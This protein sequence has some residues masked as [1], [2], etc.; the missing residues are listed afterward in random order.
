MSNVETLVPKPVGRSIGAIL[1]EAGRLKL[2]D[3]E[4]IMR[5]QREQ[6]LRFGDAALQLGLVSEAD[7][8]FA[9]SHQYGYP[10]LVRGETKVSEALVAAYT[11][12][13]PQVE[14]LRALRSQLMLRWFDVDNAHKALAVTSPGRKEGC[15]FVAAS[16]AVV[17]SQLGERTLL[18][19]GDLRNPSQHELFGVSNRVGLSTALSGRPWHDA[20]QRIP[21]LLSLSVLPAGALPPNALELLSRPV[22][23]LMLNELAQRFDV[24]L[25]DT[26]AASDCS[27]A[28]TIA[29]RAGAALIVARRN[30]TR[31]APLRALAE[32]AKEMG[33]VVVGTVFNDF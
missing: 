31:M 22:F 3:A 19:D 32:S 8:Q 10:C 29:Q 33:A 11:A 25:L 4:R 18:I 26:P 17:F 28:H 12:T 16:L 21:A 9:L 24:I 1:V 23:P 2:E 30:I 7:I 27:D 13:G 6:G 5:L 15:S 14:A 20:V